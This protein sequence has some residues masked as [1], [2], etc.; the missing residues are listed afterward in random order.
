M[1]TLAINGSSDKFSFRLKYPGGATETLN[2]STQYEALYEYDVTIATRHELIKGSKVKKTKYVNLEWELDHS[3]FLNKSDAKLINKLKNAEFDGAE[4]T[5][6]P[7][8]DAPF[9]KYR[10]HILEEKRKM[11]KHP[12]NQPNKDYVLWFENADAINRHNWIDSD[13]VPVITHVNNQSIKIII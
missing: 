5:I 12:G 4:I 7:H 2:F 13:D 1:A 8:S 3:G 10:V 6:I 11:G 9:R